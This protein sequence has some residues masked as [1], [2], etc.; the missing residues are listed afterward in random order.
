MATPKKTENENGSETGSEI[1]ATETPDASGSSILD[2]SQTPT[3]MS[4]P[5]HPQNRT[6][7]AITTM[8]RHERGRLPLLLSLFRVEQQ[9]RG[10]RLSAARH[11]PSSPNGTRAETILCPWRATAVRD[12]LPR[13]IP[14]VP[15]LFGDEQD[16]RRCTC[17][18][19]L[20]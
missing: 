5:S 20:T 7:T 10:G 3:S 12:A 18:T 16:R 14:H 19:C 17:L 11:T 13:G 15:D 8:P 1:E 9:Q 4:V 6:L 2:P